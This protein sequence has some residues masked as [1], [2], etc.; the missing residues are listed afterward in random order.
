MKRYTSPKTFVNLFRMKVFF[1]FLQFLSFQD[2]SFGNHLV[3]IHHNVP[4]LKAQSLLGKD[5]CPDWECFIITC[6]PFMMVSQQKWAQKTMTIN[7]RFTLTMS[8]QF[9]RNHPKNNWVKLCHD[10]FSFSPC[11]A[12]ENWCMLITERSR[13]LTISD[14]VGTRSSSWDMA[15]STGEQRLVLNVLP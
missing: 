10:L 5:R 14:H 13:T 2:T 8:D 3:K 12:R 11:I 7:S 6:C 9:H 4:A 1:F 15:R